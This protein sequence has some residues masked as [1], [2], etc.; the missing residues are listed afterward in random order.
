MKNIPGRGN[1]N[2]QASSTSTDTKEKTSWRVQLDP[3][4]IEK[5]KDVTPRAALLMLELERYARDK[6]ECFPGTKKLLGPALGV[7]D[8]AVRKLLAELHSKRKIDLPGGFQGRKRL[9]RMLVRLDSRQPVWNGTPDRDLE[10]QTSASNR[11]Q[12]SASTRKQTSAEEIR[13]GNQHA[14]LKSEAEKT[15]SVSPSSCG[16]APPNQKDRRIDEVL[17]RDG[18]PEPEPAKPRQIIPA[19]ILATI[20]RLV[21]DDVAGKL[22]KTPELVTATIGDR[23]QVLIHAAQKMHLQQLRQTIHEPLDYLIGSIRH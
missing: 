3:D 15:R 8:R 17:L 18:N 5:V 6:S 21:G 10:Q 19:E 23:W 2:S 7:S 11:N 12:A 16:S 1:V 22:A 13:M 14:F 9:I 20:R 4:W